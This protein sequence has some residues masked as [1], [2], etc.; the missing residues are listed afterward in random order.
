[1]RQRYPMVT[2]VRH[3][4]NLGKTKAVESGLERAQGK[5]IVL[6]DAD[7]QHCIA[8]EIEHAIQLFHSHNM[9]DMLILRRVN[10][11]LTVRL[12]RGD[13]LFTGERIMKRDDLKKIYNK[14]IQR[15]QL[16]TAINTYMM[17]EHKKVNWIAF[18]GIN[19]VKVLKTGLWRAMLDECRTIA[20]ITLGAGIGNYF[21]QVLFFARSELRDTDK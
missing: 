19:T 2:F 13:V 7:L 5:T 15:W 11:W 10:D 1:M 14:P 4:E 6:I 16:E 8:E 18:S 3:T 9:L 12:T 21:K 17:N 20:D